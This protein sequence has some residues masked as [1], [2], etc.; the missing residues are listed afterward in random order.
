[1]L[2]MASQV[3]RSQA[4]H[5]AH[6]C[7]RQLSSVCDLLGAASRVLADDGPSSL[8]SEVSSPASPASV[9]RPGGSRR[10]QAGPAF[11]AASVWRSSCPATLA[12]TALRLFS[13][14]NPA[15]RALLLL[16][17]LCRR[18]HQAALRGC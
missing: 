13:A 16:L 2:C 5:G 11:W 6:L 9:S 18:V 12:D 17:L 14:A 7:S 4:H 1:M 3:T 15:V 10:L 8:P